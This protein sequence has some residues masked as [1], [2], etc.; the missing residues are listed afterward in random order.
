[1]AGVVRDDSELREIEEALARLERGEYRLCV[2]CG[3]AVPYV[4]LAALPQAARCTRCES[5]R[6]RAQ[7]VRSRL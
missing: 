5:E 6:E 3:S 2:D 4:R 1:M 7:A